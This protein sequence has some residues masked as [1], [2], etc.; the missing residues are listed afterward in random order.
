MKMTLDQSDW[1]RICWLIEN[2]CKQGVYVVGTP[3]EGYYIELPNGAIHPAAFLDLFGDEEEPCS[4][5]KT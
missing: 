1:D 3:E 2:E 5:P 4:T